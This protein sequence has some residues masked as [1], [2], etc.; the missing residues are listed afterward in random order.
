MFKRIAIAVAAVFGLLVVSFISLCVVASFYAQASTS[1][2]L[3]SGRRIVCT[4]TGVYLSLETQKDS[5]TIRTLGHTVSIL[6]AQLQV[7]GRRLANIPV[8]TQSVNV[9]ING[10]EVTFIADGQPVGSVR[11]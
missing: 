8:S 5:A 7:D 4:A 10:G 3:P 2:Q 1:C 9:N 11:R 6:P